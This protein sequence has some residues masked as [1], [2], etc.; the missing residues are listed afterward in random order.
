MALDP[1]TLTH[2]ARALIADWWAGVRDHEKDAHDRGFDSFVRAFKDAAGLDNGTPSVGSP[3]GPGLGKES[4]ERQAV[5]HDLFQALAWIGL[6]RNK[7]AHHDDEH[8]RQQAHAAIQARLEHAETAEARH[9]S[10]D[11]VAAVRRLSDMLDL[12]RQEKVELAAD[13]A[14]ASELCY[15]AVLSLEQRLELAGDEPRMIERI[16]EHATHLGHPTSEDDV[17]A[18]ADYVYSFEALIQ[19]TDATTGAEAW[20][21]G[22]RAHRLVHPSET[23]TER[24]R[25]DDWL[26]GRRPT[27][28]LQGGTMN[29][30][31]RRR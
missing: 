19:T 21:V 23:A 15:T 4:H 24:A 29:Q 7:N 10:P 12:A 6:W 25:H 9:A 18:Y 31:G 30:A 5:A 28:A 17:I 13:M 11:N 26:M 8:E 16:A 20:N 27:G 14:A 3:V 2:G 1:G 22:A